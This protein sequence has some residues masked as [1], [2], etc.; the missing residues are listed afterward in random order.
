MKKKLVCLLLVV[1]FVF[2][3]VS[4]AFAAIPE[5]TQKRVLIDT[6][7]TEY[8]EMAAY[9]EGETVYVI[10]LFNDGRIEL[11]YAQKDSDVR[12]LWFDTESVIG[13]EREKSVIA[14]PTFAADIISYGVE[15][16]FES[17]VAS[18]SFS[19]ESSPSRGYVVAEKNQLLN[20]VYNNYYGE[21]H[22]NFDWL[23][24][25]SQ[26][27]DGLTYSYKEN[28]TVGMNYRNTAD[29]AA[30]TT[31]GAIAAGIIT[32]YGGPIAIA[33]LA[34]LL[35][36]ANDATT[37]VS[38]LG[39]LSQYYGSMVCNHFVLINGGGPYFQC[40][41]T[42]DYNGWVH[43]DE[44]DGSKDYKIEVVDNRYSHGRSVFLD[45]L[46]QRSRAYENYI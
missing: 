10:T 28:L 1:C 5:S 3:N 45:Y 34:Q 20:I 33:V 26:T 18:I 29:F 41:H 37:I 25:S 21:P 40:Y 24:M 17:E 8:Y 6:F 12:T 35:G 7:E 30:G 38:W 11:A 13:T 16:A 32:Y 15:H 14:D 19:S 46:T 42:V 27:V 9:Y 31:L 22:T 36:V 4:F 2:S 23:G 44:E 43:V 39:R